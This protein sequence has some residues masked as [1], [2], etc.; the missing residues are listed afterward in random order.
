MSEQSNNDRFDE[1]GERILPIQPVQFVGPKNPNQEPINPPAPPRYGSINFSTT[2]NG[3]THV[4]SY[5]RNFDEPWV[6]SLFMYLYL[7][8][9]PLEA[10]DERVNVALLLALQ[11]VNY[12]RQLRGVEDIR[13]NFN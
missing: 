10:K 2:I 8:G 7:H 5:R 13:M 4:T 3:T 1:W 12:G 9:Y 11:W 6:G